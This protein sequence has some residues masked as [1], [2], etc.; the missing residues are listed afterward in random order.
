MLKKFPLK[1]PRIGLLPFLSRF[2]FHKLIP[3]RQTDFPMRCSL[4]VFLS[5]RVQIRPICM[6]PRA[7]DT[8]VIYK[9]S[10]RLV[11]FC[12]CP[13]LKIKLSNYQLSHRSTHYEVNGRP[14]DT[15]M[16]C[17]HVFNFLLHSM[18]GLLDFF[19]IKKG[20]LRVESPVA[21]FAVRCLWAQLQ[22]WPYI[23]QHLQAFVIY[24]IYFHDPCYFSG[25][26]KRNRVV[27]TKSNMHYYDIHRRSSKFQ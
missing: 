3:L 18:V 16:V 5:V 10:V 14:K 23:A 17:I 24:Q 26:K 21:W 4:R 7:C 11:L 9:P 1:Q 13:C 6:Q 25:E 27:D 22:L 12:A 19:F 15:P 8:F 20:D 2:G